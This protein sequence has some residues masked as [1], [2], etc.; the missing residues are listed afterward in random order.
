M[1]FDK[2]MYR[3]GWF[4]EFNPEQQYVFDKII[5]TVTKVF[6]QYNFSHIRTPAVEPVEILKKGGDVVDKQVF[7]LF[8]LAQWVE[9]VKDYALHFDLT[10]PLARYILDHQQDITFPFK[11]YQMQPVWRGERTKRGR[12]KEFRQFDVDVVWPSKSDVGVWY[13]V[14]TVAVMDKAMH[15]VC[16]EYSLP[17]DFIVKISHLGLTKEFLQNF[18]LEEDV[19]NNVLS[20]LDGY[21]KLDHATFV[22][23]LSAL[24]SADLVKKIEE[25]ISTKD[26]SLM[27]EYASF[28]AMQQILQ[29]L[30]K[31]GVSYE[32]DICIVR[33]HNYYK[34]M[35]CE[36][37][38]KWDV[39]FGSLAAGGRYDNITDFIDKKHS[40]S[41]VG[42]SL[43]RFV[44]LAV[45]KLQNIPKEESYMFVN[46]DETYNDILDLY[47]KFLATGKRCEIYP[48]AAKLGKQFEYADKRWISHVV[49][50][51]EWEKNQGVYKIKDLASGEET[52]QS[53]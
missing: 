22:E 52:E 39:A 51:G 41:W 46:F 5:A 31:L 50:L 25:L 33:W 38:E 37:F 13:D 20:L 29:W 4:P 19:L 1:I 6:E 43:G 18:D 40:F 45:E 14:E 30:E 21:Y 15:T 34:G 27:K 53:I 24:V 7:G 47:A 11:R 10:I 23:K 3:P 17:I 9:D 26:I 44:Y 16:Q 35:V 12:F 2:K 28:G 42:T 36:W 49:I 32:Y 48:T 8:G